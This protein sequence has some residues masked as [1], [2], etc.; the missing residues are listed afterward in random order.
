[1]SNVVQLETKRRPPPEEH[2]SGGGGQAPPTYNITINLPPAPRGGG[3]MRRAAWFFLF[4]GILG[5]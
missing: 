5:R 4:L 1:M 2:G 3:F